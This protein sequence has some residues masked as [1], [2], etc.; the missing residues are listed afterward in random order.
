MHIYTLTKSTSSGRRVLA[1]SKFVECL[2]KYLSDTDS[3]LYDQQWLY[4]V[5]H[6]QWHLYVQEEDILY[7]IQQYSR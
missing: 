5:K 4:D 1:A 6:R 2:I 7:I 3:S